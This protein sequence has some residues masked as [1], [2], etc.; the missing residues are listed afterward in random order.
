MKAGP[1][2]RPPT[3]F[4]LPIGVPAPGG[5]RPVL[6]TARDIDDMR[7][8]FV[9][10]LD[11][12]LVPVLDNPTAEELRNALGRWLRLAKLHPGDAVVVYYTGHGEASKGAHFLITRETLPNEVPR[13]SFRTADLLTLLAGGE[14]SGNNP[15]KI[16]LILD[17]C[18]AG[19]ALTQELFQAVARPHVDLFVLAATHR[20][21]V[22][23]NGVFC[24]EFLLHFGAQRG[25][26][27][28]E[29]TVAHMNARLIGAGLPETVGAVVASHEFDFFLMPW[30]RK[31][32]PAP[33]ARPPP[34]RARGRTKGAAAPRASPLWIAAAAAI[35]L[36]LGLAAWRHARAPAAAAPDGMAWIPGAT[37]ELGTDEETAHSM[38]NACKE[39]S[40]A[41]CGEDFA[42]S[43][44]AR[45][46]Q[47]PGG[48]RTAV[49]GLWIDRLEVSNAQ[50]AAWL[51]ARA[52]Q[53]EPRPWGAAARAPASEG[54]GHPPGLLLRDADDRALLAV[55]RPGHPEDH[56]D[57]VYRDRR[58]EPLPGRGD[59]PA[60]L[61]SWYAADRYCRAAGKRLPTGAEWELAA[62]GEAGRAFPW[63]DDPPAGCQ[64]VAY[65]PGGCPPR[66]APAPV[67]SSTRDRT[68]EGVSD[69][70]GNVI[71]WTSDHLLP[72]DPRQ[73]EDC[74]RSP[75]RMARGAS[76]GDGAAWLHPELESTFPEDRIDAFIGFRCAKDGDP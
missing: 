60:T 44:F 42:T 34:R 75:C 76:F 59:L 36:T 28:F 32:S 53:P 17:C 40:G 67:G 20:G 61:L 43:P 52:T 26:L 9:D 38:W 1:G 4:F 65:S 47:G 6:R 18:N 63:G 72:A 14:H 8:L 30:P 39:T 27:N 13:T 46:V 5:N 58:Y 73:R 51:N 31:D 66:E 33:A 12:E 68:P 49:A 57:L 74:A 19:D 24:R 16:W 64:G 71:E 70:A 7:K 41:R 62:R 45:Q 54:G 3:R 55:A 48:A 23:F 56:G 29:A 25:E 37:I 11:Y 35:A 50:L 15:S 2:Q 21:A 22:A 10:S 69:L